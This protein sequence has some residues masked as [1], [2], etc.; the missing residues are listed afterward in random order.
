MTVSKHIE[1]VLGSQRVR[2]VLDEN[3]SPF[4]NLLEYLRNYHGL[5]SVKEGCGVGDCGACTIVLATPKTDGGLS[6]KAVNACLLFLPS[7]HGKQILAT[8]HLKHQGA[9]HP[10]QKAMLEYQGSQ[11]GYCTPGIVMSLF[12]LYKN[13]YTTE[14]PALKK[15]LSGNLCRCTGYQSI[16]NAAQAVLKEIAPDHIS[17]N[18]F[19]ISKTLLDIQSAKGPLIF[20]VERGKY[21]KVFSL[22]E[23]LEMRKDHPNALLWAGGT[24]L[25]LDIKKKQE[26]TLELIDISSIPELRSFRVENG[27]AEIGSLRS[28]ENLREDARTSLPFLSEMLDQFASLQIRNVASSGGSLAT[29]S[30]IGD[31]S[32]IFL[33]M[34]AEVELL[35][36][37]GSRRIKLLDF[38]TAYRETSLGPDEI[39]G[40]VRVPVP[41]P[42]HFTRAYKI[43]RR[44]EVDISSLSACFCVEVRDE[45]VCDIRIAYG[46][47][48]AQSLRLFPVEKFLLGKVWNRSTMEEAAAL[49]REQLHP[50]SDVRAR[51]DI[52]FKT[53]SNLFLKFFHEHQESLQRNNSNV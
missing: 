17:E 16:L 52:R 20:T 19:E 30:P 37:G 29:A 35:S 50:I 12:S 11:C 23:A 34:G 3:C 4:Q 6:Y 31:L 10:V 42:G 38:L 45:K 40:F 27:L 25:F 36:S 8:E 13:K 48:A 49:M 18:E 28:L 22:K 46:G 43:S 41:G 32:P 51:A 24:D 5:L 53:A 2:Q 26:K 7:I 33:A 39:I 9:I 15:A 1:F 44:K 21:I 47:M 14:L